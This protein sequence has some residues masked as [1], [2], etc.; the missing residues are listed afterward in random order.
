MKELHVVLEK[1]RDGRWT[2]NLHTNGDGYFFT[3][4]LGK[5][6]ADKV[7]ANLNQRRECFRSFP[8]NSA[9]AFEAI[10]GEKG[11]DFD[12]GCI[13]VNQARFHAAAEPLI[14]YMARTHNPHTR[15]IV[16]STSAELLEGLCA[17]MTEKYL[18]D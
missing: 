12:A 6:G 17:H 15:V 1:L 14:R 2:A 18:V 8:L 11:V 9:E 4:F 10:H 16:D 13:S 5:E 7:A 3:T